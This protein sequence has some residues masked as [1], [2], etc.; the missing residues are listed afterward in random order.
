VDG[1]SEWVDPGLALHFESQFQKYFQIVTEVSENELEVSGRLRADE[2]PFECRS[3]AAAARPGRVSNPA[4][5]EDGPTPI[6]VN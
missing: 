6:D 5:S 2:E 4:C 3:R 1:A